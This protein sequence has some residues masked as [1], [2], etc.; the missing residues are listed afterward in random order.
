[1]EDIQHDF[2]MIL[3]IL[4]TSFL[5]YK[6]LSKINLKLNKNYIKLE[7]H[8]D[9]KEYCFH[10]PLYK[11]EGC[12]DIY[13]NK[14][15]NYTQSRKNIRIFDWHLERMNFKFDIYHHND[16]IFFPRIKP[17][18]ISFEGLS[19]MINNKVKYIIQ[20]DEI[21]DIKYIID[22]YKKNEKE[23]IFDMDEDEFIDDICFISQTPS[24]LDDIIFKE[25]INENILKDIIPK[26]SIKF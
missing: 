10:L 11:F 9:K 25:E 23:L 14:K 13:F 18:E 20:K 17:D 2:K 22:E 7:A 3:L 19:I 24:P 26:S 6:I 15:E 5:I 21:L 8:C 16:K 1:M 4:F 12:I